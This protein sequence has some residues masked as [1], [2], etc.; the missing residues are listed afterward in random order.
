MQSGAMRVDLGIALAWLGGLCLLW[1]YFRSQ[2]GMTGEGGRNTQKE[3]KKKVAKSHQTNHG[4][5]RVDG[6]T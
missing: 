5:I 3:K 1:K 6:C 2:E 4:C